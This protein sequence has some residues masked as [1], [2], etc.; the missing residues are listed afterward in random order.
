MR[1]DLGPISDARRMLR[2][3]IN[4]IEDIELG[5]VKDRTATNERIRAARTQ[6]E[7]ALLR[8]NE[9]PESDSGAP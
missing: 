5:R 6:V 7:A 2:R 9:E 1:K 4:R 8:L 3:A